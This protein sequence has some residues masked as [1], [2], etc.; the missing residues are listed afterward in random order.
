MKKKVGIAAAV[1]LT[2][3]ALAGALYCFLGFMYKDVYP[4]FI[5]VE[6]IYCTGKTPEEVNELL[7]EKH[8][9][10]G[11]TLVDISG[12]KLHISPEDVGMSFSYLEELK[13]LLEKRS[14]FNW[15]K[16]IYRPRHVKINGYSDFDRS[17][18]ESCINSWDVL[19]RP[20]E[21]VVKIIRGENGYELLQT[22][23]NY[24]NMEEICDVAWDALTFLN[25]E[26][27]LAT[28][29][30]NYGNSCYYDKTEFTDEQKHTIKLFEQVDAIQGNEKSYSFA[31]TE[32]VL[33][34]ENLGSFILTSEDRSLIFD[35]AIEEGS[36][37]EASSEKSKNKSEENKDE[38]ENIGKGYFIVDGHILEREIVAENG[39][40]ED[41][42]FLVDEDDHLIL[43]GEKIFDYAKSLG[44]TYTTDWCIEKYLDGNGSDILFNEKEKDFGSLVDI[45]A[46]YERLV[47]LF[48]DWDYDSFSED[49]L[50]LKENVKSVSA[51][52]ALGKTFIDVNMD[53]QELKYYVD[54]K[55]S[56]E[57]P[58]VTGNVNR[59]RGTPIGVFN[60][61]NK[62]YHTY[63]R[64]ADYV[65]YVNY[66]LGV[67]KGV[68]IHDATWRSKFGEEIYKRDGS[69]GC[70]NCPLDKVSKLWEVAEVGTPVILHY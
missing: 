27:D 35:E 55:L 18:M 70:I 44:D 33:D 13:L 54:G 52:D 4:A 42:G 25:T 7:L 50:T 57:M 69:H 36:K 10:D 28:A 45:Y 43:S 22:I 61:Y 29:S 46:E 66:W 68:G 12:E 37:E 5:W 2:I 47:G 20:D 34:K 67:N 56:M 15:W 48:I 11:L 30:A 6:D 14:G 32:V 49:Q 58:I 16:S 41:N 60:V 53:K 39:I 9:Y 17:M 26:V 63:L 31:G 23:E 51:T 21:D 65:S 24:P 62:R 19:Q 40:F 1:I 3:V 8:P 64:G 38:I 59:K